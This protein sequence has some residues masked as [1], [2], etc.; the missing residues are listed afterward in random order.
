MFLCPETIF[1][2]R[3]ENW[4]IMKIELIGE[5][6]FYSS[7]EKFL[8][9]T[10]NR[11]PKIKSESFEFYAENKIIAALGLTKG[12]RAKVTFEKI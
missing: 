8:R 9:L 11:S 4:A 7:G 5:I 2:K 3:K 12:D 1:A 10:S 6:D